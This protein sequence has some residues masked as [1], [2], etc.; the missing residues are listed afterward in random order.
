MA[1]NLLTIPKIPELDKSEDY[2]LMRKEGLKYIEKLSNKLWTDYNSHDPGVTILELLCYAITDLG[3]R[4]SFSIPDLLADNPEDAAAGTDPGNF[5]TAKQILPVNPTT[6]SDIRKVIMDVP[7]VKNAW[8]SA[9]TD[10]EQPVYVDHKLCRLTLDSGKADT[11]LP[12]S[13]LYNVLIQYED[14][15]LRKEEYDAIRDSVRRRLMATRN[16]CEDYLSITQVQ[17]EDIAVCS[18]IEVRQD[19]DIVKVQA[20]IYQ[21]LVN[22]FSPP[23]YFYTLEEML[24]KGENV[25]TIFEGPLLQS[26]F[27]DDA[28][29]ETAGLRETLHTS[30][31]YN[32]IMDLPEIVAVK[33][34]SLIRY[35]NGVQDSVE[36]QWELTLGKFRAARLE[37]TKSKFIFY[38]GVLPYMASA[39]EVEDELRQ[40]QQFNSKFRKKGHKND[41]DIPGGTFRE[42]TDYF[43]VQNEFPTVYG[44]GPAGLST[45]ATDERRGQARQLKT[46]LLFYEQLFTNYLAQLA[47]T[48]KLFS[49][50]QTVDRDAVEVLRTLI[51][52]MTPAKV[53]SLKHA[54]YG[55]RSKTYFVQA[56]SESEIADLENLYADFAMYPGK[57]YEMTESPELFSERR[58]RFLDHLLARF[59]E[60]MTEYSLTLFQ[61]NNRHVKGDLL[62]GLQLIGDKEALLND[63]P[64]LSRDRGKGFNYKPVVPFIPEDPSDAGTWNTAN[65]AGMKHRVARLLGMAGTKLDFLA[66]QHLLIKGSGP[67]GK[68]KPFRV[69]LYDSDNTTILLQSKKVDKKADAEIIRESILW[70]AFDPTCFVKTSTVSTFAFN[71]VDCCERNDV[72][73]SSPDY[74]TADE[75]NTARDAAQEFFSTN[76]LTDVI[77]RRTIATTLLDLHSS[78]TGDTQRWWVELADP[79]EAGEYVLSAGDEDLF[80]EFSG[81]T[82]GKH[83]WSRECAET[84]LLYMLH[85]GDNNGRYEIRQHS[86]SGKYYYMLLNECDEPMPTAF[87]TPF[88]DIKSCQA[89]LDC[90]TRFFREYCDVEDFHLV[91]H[92]LLRPRTNLDHLVP[93]CIACDKTAQPD[94]EEGQPKFEFEV[95]LLQEKA[96]SL[97]DKHDQLSERLRDVVKSQLSKS[98]LKKKQKYKDRWGFILK[99]KKGWP[100]LVSEGYVE[101][102]NC[103]NGIAATRE[104]GTN[105]VLPV[106]PVLEYGDPETN[107]YLGN[108]RIYPQG[109]KY[110]FTL[111]SDN[112]RVIAYSASGYGSQE[113]AADVVAELSAFLAFQENIL[114]EA[115]V[116]EGDEDPYSFRI[117][118]I[119]PSWP[120]RFRNQYFRRY[121]EKVIR[122][123]TP[124]HIHPKICWVNLEQMRNFERV[125]RKWIG[126]LGTNEI[127]NPQTSRQLIRVLYNLDNV[128]PVAM[129]HSCDDIM[130][131]EPQVILDQTSLGNL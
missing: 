119:L 19:A 99:N 29:L 16:L 100:V 9:A 26:G 117:S 95:Y 75:R 124:A 62:A 70:S 129:L 51:D 61:M 112:D 79:D 57:L 21:L 41:L 123:E 106:P 34:L 66:L 11:V 101:L 53:S 8:L 80:V 48:K 88:D 82:A 98:Q 54:D 116:C 42:L 59:C 131:D 90:T 63:Y 20:K 93:A 33:T 38:K 15:N 49:F 86:V 92:I 97:K 25:D 22:Y 107:L 4:T 50:R 5:F 65:I 109:G 45:T 36:E 81:E 7:G 72:L 108:Y 78:G 104:N 18:E 24:D 102:N 103:T 3:Y 121:V 127:P 30:D 55:I 35:V 40:L 13:G 71:L 89:S 56:L 14:D 84:L 10:Y 1:E 113:E 44:I 6:A 114:P 85:N 130:G 126:G 47:N 31:L 74:A 37:K 27:I 2:E 39:A 128:Y 58:N 12:V 77:R 111:Y 87:S 94:F 115:D 122:Q 68:T 43:P 23:V 73:A 60:E 28:E 91:E 83:D 96:N 17:Y 118:V 110:R 67:N 46:Y 52:G 64:K 76:R 69:I 120:T 105:T 32:L 125:Y